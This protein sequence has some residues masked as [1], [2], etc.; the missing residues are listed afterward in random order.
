[1]ASGVV[2][3]VITAGTTDAQVITIT[4]I[5]N[6]RNKEIDHIVTVKAGTWKFGIG[7]VHTDAHEFTTT[8]GNNVAI[9]CCYPGQLWGK[10]SNAADTLFVV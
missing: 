6:N 7:G 9:I 4:N 1:M 10:A 8:T 5:G 3:Q 2:G